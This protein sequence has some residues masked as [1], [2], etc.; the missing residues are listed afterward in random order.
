MDLAEAALL[1]RRKGQGRKS[2]KLLR[3][4]F[5]LEATVATQAVTKGL[6]EPSRSILLRS[7]AALALQ[8]EE[9]TQAEHF[10]ALGLSGTP[11]T[12]IAEHLRDLLEQS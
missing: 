1:A 11:P 5:D 9:Q 3:Q 12:E 2:R 6:P 10:A 4:A 8:C 7:A